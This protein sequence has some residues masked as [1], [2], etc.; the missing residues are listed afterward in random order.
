[1]YDRQATGGLQMRWSAVTDEQGR[2]RLVAHW[3]IPTSVASA[4]SIPVTGTATAPPSI[5]HAA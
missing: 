5:S 3:V 2:Q 1:M 4:P